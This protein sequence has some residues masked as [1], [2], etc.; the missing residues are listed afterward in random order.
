MSLIG[1][2]TDW[3]VQDGYVASV[4]SILLSEDPKFQIIDI[5]HHIFPQN[6][7]MAGRILNSCERFFPTKSVFVCVVDPGVGSDRKIIA[8]RSRRKIFLAPDNGLLTLMVEQD[9]KAVIR[10][11]LWKKVL[12]HCQVSPTFHGRDIFAP[13]AALLM[14]K[15]SFFDRLGPLLKSPKMISRKI[16][17]SKNSLLGEIVYFDHFGNALTNITQA[18][19]SPK[20][21]ANAHIT[22]KGLKLGV[23]IQYY[24]QMSHNPSALF[25]SDGY[26]ELA[27][28]N[29]S[30]K[31]K[32]GLVEGQVVNISWMP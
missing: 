8:L 29:G 6:I 9:P 3:G 2:L 17:I 19:L 20:Q 26:L 14:K 21:W 12:P 27:V 1:L 30:F 16:R 25:S 31:Q 7:E 18:D 28:K 32:T 15:F 22:V 10:E 4:K 11:V 5:S 23:P 24:S 13:I